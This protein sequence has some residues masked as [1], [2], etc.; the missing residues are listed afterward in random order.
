MRDFFGWCVKQGWLRASPADGIEKVGRA[1]KGKLQL[2]GAEARALLAH[3][4]RRA[5]EGDDGGLAVAV[6]LSTGAC[7]GELLQRRVRDVDDVGG[8]GLLLWIDEQLGATV[9]RPSRRRTLWVGEPVATVL[10]AHVKGRAPLAWLF[11]GGSSGGARGKTW[12]RK[13][14]RRLCDEAEVQVVC[15]HGLR[16]TW[17]SLGAA[18]GAARRDLQADL[19]HGDLRSQEAY[20]DATAAHE[21]TARRMLRL[22][23]GGE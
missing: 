18:E 8:R 7:A 21:G 1:N 15:P 22:V 5:A 20:V 4:V 12:L 17:A 10:R 19:G 3:A 16:G 2:R 6:I 9:K 11:P 14:T 23:V 13:V